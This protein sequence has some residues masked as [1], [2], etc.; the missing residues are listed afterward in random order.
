MTDPLDM[1]RIQQKLKT[2]EYADVEE[3]KADFQK[4]GRDMD[5]E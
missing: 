4:V 5:F 2:E 3:L 1:L